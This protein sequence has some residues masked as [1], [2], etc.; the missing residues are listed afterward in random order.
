MGKFEVFMKR[1]EEM[2]RV[3]AMNSIKGKMSVLRRERNRRAK[4]I[5]RLLAFKKKFAKKK[6]RKRR[7]RPDPFAF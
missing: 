6:K 2:P 1:V 5:K 4:E 3:R 7:K